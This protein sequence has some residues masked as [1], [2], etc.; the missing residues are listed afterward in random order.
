MLVVGAKDALLWCRRYYGH[1]PTIRPNAKKLSRLFLN[2]K[3]MT[4]EE[5]A[6][7][8]RTHQVG[9]MGDPNEVKPGR[10]EFHENPSSCICE[11]TLP[12]T[13]DSS[14]HGNPAIIY[15]NSKEHST[16]GFDTNDTNDYQNF[17]D[18]QELVDTEDVD[19]VNTLTERELPQS[20][21]KDPGVTLT[22]DQ[23]ELEEIL[24]D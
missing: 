14:L 3:N 21:I 1:K 6:L 20:N 15:Q 13:E 5:F 12:S 18:E 22:T 16:I 8:I 2:Q 9:F 7:G 11:N 19:S 10:S 17:E 24:S 4:W 23:P